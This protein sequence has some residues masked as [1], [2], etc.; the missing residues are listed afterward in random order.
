MTE[1]IE[2]AAGGPDG[3][4]S[5]DESRDVR[6]LTVDGREYVLVGTAHISQQSVDL[7]RQVIERERP[8]AVCV[9]L[10]E[11][12]FE[13]LS[14]ER[15]FE[16]QDLRAV[17]R[18]K[19]L[20]TLLM[21]L[22]LASYQKRLGM[23]LGVTPRARAPRGDPGRGGARH[24]R[25]PLRSRRPHH[26]APRV[27]RAVCSGASSRCSRAFSRARSRRPRSPRRSSRASV[28]GTC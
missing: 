10:D 27:E 23:K 16:A 19:Q 6:R 14:Q 7:V 4:A 1:K 28:T 22:L 17:I 11:Q 25:L 9:E 26:P 20:A 15:R 2:S 24:P 18:N 21:N 13:A 12:R 3:N 5:A 8:D